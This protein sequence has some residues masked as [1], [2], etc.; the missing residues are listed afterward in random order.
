MT[1]EKKILFIAFHPIFISLLVSILIIF[2]F[3]PKPT[4]YIIHLDDEYYH[5]N[6][7]AFFYDDLDGNGYSDEIRVEDYDSVNGVASLFVHLNPSLYLNEWD[8]KGAYSFTCPGFIQTGDFDN[9]GKKEIY[10]FTVSS[11]SI[12][13]SI[14]SDFHSKVANYFKYKRFITTFEPYNGNPQVAILSC[15][16]EDMNRDGYKDLVFAICSGFSFKPRNVYIYDIHRDSLSISPLNGYFIS[17]LQI[18]DINKDGFKEIIANGYASQ[19]VKDSN[20]I[21]VHDQCCW[22]I[23]LDHNLHYLFPPRKFPYFGY[24]SLRTIC[25]AN[26]HGTFDLYSSYYP[27]ESSGKC[28][29]LYHFNN[30]GKVLRMDSIPGLFFNQAGSLFSNS[31]K[32]KVNIG[33]STLDGNIFFFDT[34]LNETKKV[35]TKKNIPFQLET[36]DVDN[37]GQKEIISIDQD[38]S[39][40]TIFRY[41]FSS[42]TSIRLPTQDWGYRLLSL[43]I[44]PNH[45]PKLALYN[46][47]KEFLFSYSINQYYYAQWGVYMGIFITIYLFILLIRKIQKIQFE[48]QK[49][50]EK[51][52]TELQLKI[53]RNQMDPH[54]TMNAVN[55]VIAS[56]NQNEKEQASLHLLHFSD[57]YR[58][59]VL[60]A[61]KI[62]CTLAEEIEF[63]RNYLIMEQFRYKDKFLFNISIHPG[64]NLAWEVPKMVIQ[65]PVENAIKHGLLNFQGQGLLQINAQVTDHCL[66]LDVIDNG[67]GRKKASEIASKSTGKGMKVMDEFLEL[68]QKITGTKVETEVLDLFD[69]NN[70]PL[71]TKVSIKIYIG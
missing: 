17:D 16:L 6:C 55:S 60:T 28:L 34:A 62:K 12:F 14:V 58:H 46:H 15:K 30:R 31:V 4:K 1:N 64:V 32:E 69:A 33:L 36:L 67:I 29:S 22:L 21:K 57:M 54:F 27:P 56:I 41:D 65:S 9:N 40:L 42:P 61:D 50:I 45:P 59:L 20:K 49:K 53:V 8:F 68:Y 47:N 51:K 5:A 2:L 7:P 18:K 25:I 38:K 70:N 52:I 13:L 3:V 37:D 66:V 10:I 11:D 39:L 43:K 71:G 63:T 35:V 44:E 19:N 26:Q 48:R 23:V 24:S